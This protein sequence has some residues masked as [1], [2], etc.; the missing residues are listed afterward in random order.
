[1]NRGD[2]KHLW[3]LIQMPRY[4]EEYQ[5]LAPKFRSQ[6]SRKI[7]ELM[8]DPT[9]G[10]SR[11]SLKGYDQLCRLRAGDFRVIYAYDR[12][13]VQLMS[14][15]RRDEKTYDDL[16]ELEVRQFAAF[17]TITGISE[18]QRRIPNWNDVPK[19]NDLS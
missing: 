6:I 2:G 11:T 8:D 5:R 19:E 7:V 1:M 9:P 14:L 12:D 10:G 15:R 13:V 3:G 4:R 18:P 17:R 16:D